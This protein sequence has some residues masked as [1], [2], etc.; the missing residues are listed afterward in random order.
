MW[1][2][3]VYVLLVMKMSNWRSLEVLLRVGMRWML[4][5]AEP[6]VFFCLAREKSVVER[7]QERGRLLPHRPGKKAAGKAV[8]RCWCACW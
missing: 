4:A 7:K 8:A 6:F 5:L 2:L 3:C 1:I